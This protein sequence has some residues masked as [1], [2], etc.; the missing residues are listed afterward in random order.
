MEFDLSRPIPLLIVSDGPDAHTGLARICHDLAWLVSSM[1][2]FKVGVLGR[3]A[4]GRSV[5]P[6]AQYSF[7]DRE[8]WGEGRI[9]A[10]WED[11]S[12]GLPGVIFT[13]WDA[14]RLLW[15]ANPIGLPERL[16]QFL[17]P[18]RTFEKWGYFMQD[19]HG[20]APDRL[21]LEVAEVF[22]HYDR[23]CLASKW[24]WRATVNTINRIPDLDWMPHGINRDTF[25]PVDRVY[26][27]SAWG[28]GEKEALIGCVM[29]NQE[30]K[31]WPAMF[32]AVA[33]MKGKPKLWVHTDQLFGYWNVQ[34]LAVEYGLRGQVIVEDREITDR[35]MAARYSA[36]DAT[37][38]ISGGEGFCYPVA[39]SLSCGTPVVAG[40]Y[41]AQAELIHYDLRVKPVA[42]RIVTNHNARRAVYD[43]KDVAE[44]LEHAVRLKKDNGT[45]LSTQL[46]EHLDHRK[47]GVQ[48][49]KWVG[50][51]L[52]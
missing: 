44:K 26:L 1:P 19:S 35:G 42:Y 7:S 49:K 16:Q 29:S 8:Q 14:S 24:A 28:V 9:E 31:Y 12:R 39:E 11:L 41:G 5:F 51:G 3:M 43:G 20:V 6:W 48:W 37:A 10:A 36:C 21:P 18:G 27:R 13:I 2:E 25:Q 47:L 17:G 15:F 32:E 52:Q 33:L 38:V 40:E 34:A 23:V 30:R 46:V 50:R 22:S 4:F 45:E